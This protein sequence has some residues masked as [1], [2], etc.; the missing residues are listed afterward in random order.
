MSAYI[1]TNVISITDG[2]I[3]LETDLFYQGIRPADFGGP[4][5]V[6]RGFGR[7]DQ[8]HQEG[9]RAAPS[10]TWRSSA[11]CRRSPSSVPISTR[12][13][14]AKHRA[15]PAHRGAVQAAPISA[16]CRWRSRWSCCGPCR[17]GY[18]DDVPVDRVKEF[19]AQ[20]R[21]ILDHPQSGLCSRRSRKEKT[22]RQKSI[23]ARSR[24]RAMEDFKQDVEI[25]SVS[26]IRFLT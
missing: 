5:G 24:R 10:W 12:K 18:F 16:R 6:P 9:G 21:G 13:T 26:A 20:A 1:P 8:G 11:N 2:Q 7:A 22:D 17:T 3:Y 15:R 19:Q 23:T 14:K 25:R 4:L